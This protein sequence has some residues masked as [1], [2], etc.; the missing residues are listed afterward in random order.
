M[1][2]LRADARGAAVAP[3]AN[4]LVRLDCTRALYGVRVFVAC[5]VAA[6]VDVLV[7]AGG[8]RSVE[9]SLTLAAG[10]ASSVWIAAPAG[11]VSVRVT[12][13]ASGRASASIL[14][15]EAPQ[16]GNA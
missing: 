4:E 8:P 12:T 3:G 6:S 13:T 7:D 5:D 15:I 9:T 1:R 16:Y 14:T 11:W 2:P 10:A